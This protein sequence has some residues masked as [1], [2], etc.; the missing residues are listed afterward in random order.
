MA[1]G[2]G[3][4]EHL[5]EQPHGPG[6]DLLGAGCAHCRQTDRQTEGSQSQVWRYL[7]QDEGTYTPDSRK[8][9]ARNFILAALDTNTAAK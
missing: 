2:Q 1:L 7:C 3:A 5:T 8:S 9:R 4:L 6:R